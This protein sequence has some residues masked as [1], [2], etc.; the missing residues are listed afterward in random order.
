MD[1]TL[2]AEDIQ[3]IRDIYA[4]GESRRMGLNSI[5][6]LQAQHIPGT[7]QSI[8][9]G[10]HAVTVRIFQSFHAVLQLFINRDHQMCEAYA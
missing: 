10:N 7:F 8:Q 9:S 4:G 5:A 2:D 6:V 1:H 3:L